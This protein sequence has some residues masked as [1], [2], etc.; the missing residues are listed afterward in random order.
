MTGSLDGDHASVALVAPGADAGG[1]GHYTGHL[2]EALGDDVVEWVTLDRQAG[3]ASF[4]WAALRAGRTG[5]D[6]I[7]LQHVYGLFGEGSRYAWV[8]L[9]VLWLLATARRRP[10]VVTV[11]EVWT[12]ETPAPPFAGLKRVYVRLVN[13]TVSAL[14]ARVVFLSNHSARAF[15]PCYATAATI[16]HGVREDTVEMGPATAKAEFGFDAEETVVA[17]FGYVNARKGFDVFVAIADRVPEE[18]FLLAGGPRRES[19]EAHYEDLLADAPPNLTATGTLE[20]ERFHAAFT[21]ADVALLPYAAIY[22]SGIFN[23]CAA[24]GLVVLASDI[25]Y[26]R[27]L[28]DAEDCVALFEAGDPDDGASRLRELLTDEDRRRELSRNVRRYAD[29]NRFSQVA[30]RHR[31]VYDGVTRR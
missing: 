2:A 20:D 7:H 26:F 16:E 13:A 22:Q 1:V 31:E 10:V 4:L 27:D 29:R 11:H 14:A 12:A 9:P 6:V 15:R 24:Y 19:F 25:P 17:E 18:S 3:P 8:F 21:A 30:A 5:A 23:W 28:A